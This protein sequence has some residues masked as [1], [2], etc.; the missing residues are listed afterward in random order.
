MI[1]FPVTRAV[2]FSLIL[3]GNF[4]DLVESGKLVTISVSIF[5]NFL[6]LLVCLRFWLV[7]VAIL[8]VTLSVL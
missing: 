3:G 1:L 7:V 6:N 2:A 8:T 4:D 5:V